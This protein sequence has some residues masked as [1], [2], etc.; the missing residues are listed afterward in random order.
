[1]IG[2]NAQLNPRL[3]F[4]L[5]ISRWVQKN[6]DVSVSSDLSVINYSEVLMN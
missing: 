6:E 4:E 1:M 5:L 3:N 2:E